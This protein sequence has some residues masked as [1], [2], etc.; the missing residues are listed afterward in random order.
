MERITVRRFD[1]GQDIE[2]IAVEGEGHKWLVYG[3]NSKDSCRWYMTDGSAYFD[4]GD[5]QD[6]HEV[7]I[8]AIVLTADPTQATDLTCERVKRQMLDR[9][10]LK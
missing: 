8:L 9:G 10:A 3:L 4:L 5:G 6:W 2:S 7:Y 1:I